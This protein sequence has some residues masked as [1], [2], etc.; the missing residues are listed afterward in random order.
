LIVA[1]A[2]FYKKNIQIVH[3]VCMHDGEDHCEITVLIDD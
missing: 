1:S 2:E 3:S